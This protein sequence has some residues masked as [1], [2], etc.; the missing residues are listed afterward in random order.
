MPLLA[1][2][3]IIATLFIESLVMSL[4]RYLH[5]TSSTKVKIKSKVVTEYKVPATPVGLPTGSV[6]TD[7]R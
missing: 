6:L 1:L 7:N 2:P 5:Y 3:A 4:I